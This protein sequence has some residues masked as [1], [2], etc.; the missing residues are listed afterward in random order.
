MTLAGVVGV[1]LDANGIVVTTSQPDLIPA[2]FEDLPVRVE[3]VPREL[4]DFLP[5]PRSS[6]TSPRD[7][8]ITYFSSVDM[9]GYSQDYDAP[10]N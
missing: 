5:K 2:T 9:Y 3:Y 4:A 1:G 7:P 8:S 6:S 10:A